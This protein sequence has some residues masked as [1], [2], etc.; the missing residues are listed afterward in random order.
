MT[1]VL[2]NLGEIVKNLEGEI[3]RIET[4]AREVEI[5][6][7]KIS[8]TDGIIEKD[9]VISLQNVDLLIQTAEDIQRFLKGLCE[10]ESLE[11]KVNISDCLDLLH[12]G[13]TR[14]NLSGAVFGKPT[15][16]EDVTFFQ[17]ATSC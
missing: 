15:E 8:K 1:R 9:D 16:E 2:L 13:Q 12:L 3:F 5:A 6:F 11:V 14:R 7:M 10:S 17:D 4:M